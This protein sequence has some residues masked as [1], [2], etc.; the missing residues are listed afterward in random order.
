[1]VDYQNNIEINKIFSFKFFT[2]IGSRILNGVVVFK[3][4][5]YI[6]FHSKQVYQLYLLV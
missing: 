3:L 5:Q 1:M 2:T 4:W 6:E